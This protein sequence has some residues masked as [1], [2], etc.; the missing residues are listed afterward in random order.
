MKT[1]LV[2]LGKESLAR[3]RKDCAYSGNE[4][5]SKDRA[6]NFGNLNLCTFLGN[7]KKVRLLHCLH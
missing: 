7:N 1:F 6:I 5:L 2:G 3:L 4:R